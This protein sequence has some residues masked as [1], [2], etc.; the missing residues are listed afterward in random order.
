MTPTTG[1]IEPVMTPISWLKPQQVE[2]RR[3]HRRRFC[4]VPPRIAEAVQ[5]PRLIVVAPEQGVPSAARLHA[6]APLG[7][8]RLQRREAEPGAAPLAAV[9][10]VDLQMMELNAIES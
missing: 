5:G 3:Q 2:R 8:Q 7:E 9:L 6:A 1:I 10:V 4:P